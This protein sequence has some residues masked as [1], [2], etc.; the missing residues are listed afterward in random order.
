MGRSKI[1]DESKRKFPIEA[2]IEREKIDL[3][4]KGD[5]KKIAEKALDA[6]Y[7]KLILNK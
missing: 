3:I 5:C 7:K 4:G 2:W 1:E 6:E